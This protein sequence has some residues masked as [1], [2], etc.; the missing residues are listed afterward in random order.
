MT[1]PR[2]NIST[3]LQP[4]DGLNHDSAVRYEVSPTHK[5]EQ[6]REY[7]LPESYN[8]LGYQNLI[9]MTFMLMS[10]RD[11]WMRV[12][13][14]GVSPVAKDQSDAFPPLH[15]VLV[16]EPEAHLH[17]QVQQVFIRKA[18]DV[19]RNN[20]ALKESNTFCTQLV[21]ST[22]SSHIAHEAP[23]EFL[24]YFRRC[25]ADQEC[26]VPT[27]SVV[28]LTETF[29]TEDDT[30]RFVTRY[31]RSTHCDLFFADAAILVEG[32]AERILVPEFIVLHYP[33]LHERYITLLEIGGS[34]A[35]R[36]RPLIEELGC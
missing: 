33:E 12:G 3:K 18:Y 17:A 13:K 20:P 4:T 36:L 2:L 23:F 7:L 21:V 10:F 32:S 5:G 14:A 31:L 11:E 35:H 29:G 25:P 24:R 30:S 8:G 34:H 22:H 6:E 9:S 15:L 28:N 19:L 1:D 27:T 26:D 16:E